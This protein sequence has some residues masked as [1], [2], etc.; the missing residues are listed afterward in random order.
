MSSKS[1]S[2]P[3][4]ALPAIGLGLALS[5]AWIFW[6][7]GGGGL[8]AA[9]TAAA[10]AGALAE[11]TEVVAVQVPV[12]VVRNGEPVRGLTAADFEVYDGRRKQKVTGFEVLDLAGERGPAMAALAPA[13]RR[14]FLLLFDLSF[15]EPSSIVKA[16]QMVREML[17][18]LHPSDLV[19]VASYS[20]ANGPRLL[21]GF[22]SDRRQ[23]SQAIDNLG[24]PQL[25]DRNP[26]P[27]Q[28]IAAQPDYGKAGG[29]VNEDNKDLARMSERANR[30][31]QQAM[32]GALA[33]SFTDLARLLAGIHGRKEVIYL[34]EG[35]DTSLLQGSESVAD[36][37]Q[38]AEMTV[39]GQGYLTDSDQRYGDTR[40]ANVLEKMMEEFRRSDCIIQSIDI[41]GARTQSPQYAGATTVAVSKTNGP[42]QQGE[43]PVRRSGEGALFAMAHDTGG[44]LY[45]NF[46]DLGVAMGQ[47]LKKT[48]VTYVLTFQPDEV[49]HD[50]SF[51]KLRVELKGQA[52]KGA[53]VF[54]RPGYY[55]PKPYSQ[56][57]QKE[58]ILAAADQVVGGSD[59]GA[60][61]TALLVAPFRQAASAP[62]AA[63]AGV[64]P[65][66][67]VGD[68]PDA[69][70]ARDAGKPGG[71]GSQAATDKAYV[72]VVIEADGP[73]L[74]EGSSGAALP[75]EIYAYAI[76]SAG[77]I[78]DFFSQSLRLDLAKAAPAL[79]RGGLKFF[80]HL[81][82]PPGE[83][84]VRVLVRNG[85][86]GAYG[87]R[88]QPLV[89]PAFGEPAAVLLQPFFPEAPGRWVM[90]K[91]APRQKQQ[92]TPPPYPFVIQERAYVPASL[93]VVPAGQEVAMALVG[94]HL[95]AGVFRGRA[96]LLAAD[97]KDLGEG[98]LKLGRRESPDAE[99]QERLMATFRPPRDFEPGE[100]QLVIVLTD[101]QGGAHQTASRFVVPPAAAP[102]ALPPQGSGG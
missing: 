71:A 25:V 88:S 73:T 74:L 97:G 2:F 47:L 78:Q 36:Q 80:G 48:S 45:H 13:L 100:Y 99:G 51:H 18:A 75:A 53:Q 96:R 69:G 66:S 82:L 37:A 11:T 72:P 91:E 43:A 41:G 24:L 60:V 27:L 33:R 10:K 29:Y 28:L 4:R 76:D 59:S 42:S 81:D 9:P 39:Q 79:R 31:Q 22:T 70:N 44:E 52:G 95:P 15:S 34:S 3:R 68:A 8:W 17:P 77:A 94:Y 54:F 23:V 64:A 16:R 101:A 57:S 85:A 83:Y 84:N 38:M 30:Q 102:T 86:T 90:V 46:N 49:K 1:S 63:P 5:A 14:H 58:K 98:E 20:S 67:A 50:G 56:Q 40:G 21:L 89:V 92:E 6:P 35:F 26:D 61:R 87:L 32:V 62:Q 55:V 19:A 12:Q 65:A 93:P 7:A